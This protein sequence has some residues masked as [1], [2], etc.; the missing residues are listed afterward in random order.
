MARRVRDV[1]DIVTG[2]NIRRYE[3]APAIPTY[4]ITVTRAADQV[5]T[6]T[7]RPI[8]TGDNN[9]SINAAQ[10]YLATLMRT[11]T[12]NIIVNETGWTDREAYARIFGQI[13][14]TNTLNSQTI[15]NHTLEQLGAINTELLDG[16]FTT[17]QQSETEIPFEALE[18]MI[19]IAPQSFAFGAGLPLISLKKGKAKQLSWQNH[20]DEFG[21]INCAAIALTIL[22]FPNKHYQEFPK[23]LHK[24]ARLLQNELKWGN[25][26]SIAE[27]ND[28][29]LAYPKFRL[30]C[31]TAVEKD[32]NR[33]TF[34][35]KD[36]DNSNIDNTS[37]SNKNPFIIYVYFDYQQRHFAAETAPAAIYKTLY[38]YNMRFCHRCIQ[39]FSPQVDHKCGDIIT[40]KKAGTI[41]KVICDR[42]EK[43]FQKGTHNCA[44]YVCINCKAHI[45]KGHQHLCAVMVHEKEDLGYWDGVSKFQ[46]GKPGLWVFD[47]EASMEKIYVPSYTL[48]D[49]KTDEAE[50][51]EPISN[52]AFY[53]NMTPKE[54]KEELKT[55]DNFA[56]KHNL[57]LICLKNCITGQKYKFI[58]YE[59][60]DD[61]VG[62]MIDLLLNLNQGD[63][64]I[65]SHNGSGY[66]SVL[67]YNYLVNSRKELQISSINNG[68]KFLE[69]TV[70][71]PRIGRAISIIFWTIKT[72]L[73]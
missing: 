43:E 1:D 20:S 22:A 16:I 45:P 26:V 34:Y 14:I 52:V 11:I 23:R 49:F 25:T 28:F 47:I 70:H 29:V 37:N 66:D 36:F 62:K 32:F 4:D 7:F 15:R 56:L 51:L 13:Q 9:F 65:L 41:K 58:G 71:S 35:G 60:K 50:I 64:I 59:V 63:H 19:I 8:T 21:P 61:P 55:S 3:E 54:K 33:N 24:R 38:N 12:R 17:L 68:S 72:H 40:R 42:C 67:I 73:N 44:E 10:T 5:H 30:T 48:Y 18:W 57:N 2:R 6:I 69:L 53:T 31:L 39:V 27:L 46:K